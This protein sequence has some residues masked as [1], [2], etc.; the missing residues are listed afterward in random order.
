VYFSSLP[1]FVHMNSLRLSVNWRH[2]ATRAITG[3]AWAD[4]SALNEVET[5]RPGECFEHGPRPS[6]QQYW[7][8]YAIAESDPIED[9]QIAAAEVRAVTRSCLH[10]WAS[11][12]Q[13]SVH[14]L[15]GGLDS[16]IVLG[17]LADAPSRPRISCLNFRTQDP[18][19]DEREYARLAAARAGCE[20]TEQE[21]PTWHA[22]ERILDCIPT[23]G[24]A[25][26][27]MRGL[28]VQPLVNRFAEARGATALFS[29][30]GGDMLFFHGWPQLAVIDYA[31]QKG[32]PA[33]LFK[34]ACDTALPAQLSIWRLLSDA[35]SHG[36]LHRKWNIQKIVFD[37]YRLITDD[38]AASALN[39][40]D[41][42][43]PWKLPVGDIPPGK[44]LHTFISTRPCLFRDPMTRQP[45]IDVV[46]PLVSQPVVETCLRIPTYIHA[47]G[48]L[49]R[50][51]ARSA[52][53]PDL[54][55]EIALRT[56][57]GA[58]DGH[59]QAMLS[60]NIGFVRE[61]LMDGALVK[62]NILDRAKLEEC[63]SGR[64]SR[65]GTHA[66]EVFGYVCTE[67][68]LRH[69]ALPAAVAQ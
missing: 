17:C 43:N 51:I 1:D 46:N 59:L 67:A 44:M 33:K 3:N 39:D 66:T 54:P 13:N 56:W 18:D 53:A 41:L 8:P 47:A 2:I 65:D 58:A 9:M 37:H 15:S 34:F 57:K 14:V 20:L 5:V 26:V 35:I 42:L 45:R 19:S 62:Q 50:A 52:F 60:G 69:W 23:V 28:E 64:P 49:D 10:A 11:I 25:S 38:A 24:P 61:L 40:I 7:N 68:W 30:D 32:G 63:L 21:R 55:R 31:H 16:S 12:H 48:G 4:E 27:I 6:R 22:V 29:G 36:V